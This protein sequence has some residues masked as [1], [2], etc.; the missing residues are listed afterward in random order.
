MENELCRAEL[1]ASQ[2]AVVL[3]ALVG[4]VMVAAALYLTKGTD[5]ILNKDWSARI[6]GLP[7]L[8]VGLLGLVFLVGGIALTIGMSTVER[9]LWLV[10]KL[11]LVAVRVDDAVEVDLAAELLSQVVSRTDPKS[12]V[13]VRASKGAGM[14]RVSGR[15]TAACDAALLMQICRKY[16]ADL[17]CTATK[18]QELHVCTVKEGPACKP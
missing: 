11:P 6:R 12:G 2:S 17:L 4:A 8:A 15:Y 7:I 18:G 9:R 5:V 14:L 10:E 13:I 3:V 16:G 1:I